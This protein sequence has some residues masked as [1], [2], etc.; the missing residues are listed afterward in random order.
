MIFKSRKDPLVLGVIFTC[1]IT[2]I[3]FLL[4]MYIKEGATL[5]QILIS[6]IPALTAIGILLWMTFRIQYIIGPDYI[7][8]VAGFYKERIKINAIRRID[9]D[10]T[11]WMGLKLAGA[12]KGIIIYYH[13][14][15]EIYLS[16]DTYEQFISE[17]L[18]VNPAIEIHKK[19]A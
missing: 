9:T 8:C 4:I 10:T 1:C 2:I 12:R 16:P 5:F 18:K 14:Y 7:D 15:A 17:L 3:I 19:S 6:L 11:M 13:T